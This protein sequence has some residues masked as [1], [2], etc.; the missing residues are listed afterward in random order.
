MSSAPAGC[1]ASSSASSYACPARL[2][3]FERRIPA[4]DDRPRRVCGDC[5][6][7]DWE[8]PKMVVGAVCTWNDL[9]LLCRRAI[10]P[11]RGLWTLPAGHLEP[12]ETLA[13]GA[14]REALE[15]A[16]A[17]IRI[18]AL[19][20]IYDIPRAAALDLGESRPGV[21]ELIHRAEL[22]SPDVAAGS[23]TLEARLF[24]WDEIPWDS[25]AF[26][27]VEWAL[28]AHREVAGRDDF[29]PRRNPAVGRAAPFPARED[30]CVLAPRSRA[31]G[32]SGSP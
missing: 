15:E 4:G 24:A 8:N 22:L 5:G 6:F 31:A 27:S 7:V 21:V 29:A 3:R 2:G 26:P 16:G 1:S 11:S 20:A 19:L 10:E 13:E 32:A 9:Y 30:A 23:E 12:G 25:L 14:A 18:D 17:H 28:R